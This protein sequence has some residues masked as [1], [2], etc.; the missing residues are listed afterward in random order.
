MLKVESLGTLQGSQIPPLSMVLTLE[1]VGVRVRGV[2]QWGWGT[3]WL[4]RDL[5][6]LGFCSQT[7][8]ATKVALLLLLS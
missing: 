2:T 4:S 6:V 5:A 7:Q 8:Q 1:T 3:G